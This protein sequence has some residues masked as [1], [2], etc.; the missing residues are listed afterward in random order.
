MVP[1]VQFMFISYGTAKGTL[2]IAQNK[3]DLV[4][5]AY[6]IHLQYIKTHGNDHSDM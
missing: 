6:M 4:K 5:G 1:Y 3:N 2:C